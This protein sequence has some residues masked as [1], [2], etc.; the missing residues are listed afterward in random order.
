MNTLKNVTLSWSNCLPKNL[1]LSSWEFE[2][3]FYIS[4]IFFCC[5]S[6][7]DSCAFILAKCIQYMSKNHK[8][9]NSSST[10]EKSNSKF[11]SD[12]PGKLLV[13]R[14]TKAENSNIQ[15]RRINIPIPKKRNKGIGRNRT[16][17][18]LKTHRATLNLTVTC[19]APG[20]NFSEMWALR[21]LVVLPLEHYWWHLSWPLSQ[22]PKLSSTGIQLP[23]VSTS[24]S[25]S[26]PELCTLPFPLSEAGCLASWVFFWNLG[27]SLNQ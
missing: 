4:A 1:P 11:S 9:H 8:I 26:I 5:W 25:V 10:A 24:L 6:S 27:G 18:R 20:T 23:G 21:G 19:P 22:C 17:A 13:V 12:T 14:P 16:K 2:G 15:R 7:K 3:T